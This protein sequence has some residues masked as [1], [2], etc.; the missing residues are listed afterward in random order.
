MSPKLFPPARKALTFQRKTLFRTPDSLTLAR[1]TVFLVKVCSHLSK[2]NHFPPKGFVF[3]FCHSVSP[4]LGQRH[5]HAYQVRK[6]RWHAFRNAPA[7]PFGDVSRIVSRGDT[8]F[9]AGR[10]RTATTRVI[11]KNHFRMEQMEAVFSGWARK[12]LMA[13]QRRSVSSCSVRAMK[14]QNQSAFKRSQSR[15][16]GLKSGE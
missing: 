4:C 15:S 7:S 3:L 9:V 13:V 2:E 6:R 16:M 5:I 12:D 11:L 1:E 10:S 8:S 14:S